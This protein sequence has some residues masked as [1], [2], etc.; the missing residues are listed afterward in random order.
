[1][2]T[3]DK[4]AFKF[5]PRNQ[6]GCGEVQR[7]N[8][9]WINEV[10][11]TILDQV[12]DLGWTVYKQPSAIYELTIQHFSSSKYIWIMSNAV[13]Q[14]ICLRSDLD[15]D[16]KVGMLRFVALVYFIVILGNF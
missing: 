15:I 1:M 9:T 7:Q 6:L 13:V 4:V 14:E 16:L 5:I 12:Y 10:A 11:K 3:V 8:N 2:E